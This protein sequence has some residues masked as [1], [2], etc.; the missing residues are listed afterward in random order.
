MRIVSS[1][2][3]LALATGLISFSTQAKETQKSDAQIRQ[4][5]MQES[6]AGYPGNCPCPYNAD[7][8]GRSCGKRSAWSR[9]GG[10][11]PI[12]Y[13]REVTKDMIAQYRQREN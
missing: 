9:G 13:E 5:I 12:C 10:Y 7:A 11:A 1:A 6:K 4:A 2:L 8:R 3:L